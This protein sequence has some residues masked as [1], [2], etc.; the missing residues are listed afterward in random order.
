MVQSMRIVQRPDNGVN[1]H[2][3]CLFDIHDANWASMIA[4]LFAGK[5]DKLKIENYY[6][7]YSK[8]ANVIKD[9]ETVRLRYGSRFQK[10]WFHPYV[11]NKSQKRSKGNSV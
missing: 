6:C 1:D 8:Q 10:N 2:L 7:S 3:Y 5:L 11:K 9:L 4:E